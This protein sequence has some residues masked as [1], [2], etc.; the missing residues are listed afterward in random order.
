MPA[1]TVTFKNSTEVLVEWDRK[2]HMG[3]PIDSYEVLVAHQ[4]LRETAELHANG[5]EYNML[6]SLDTVVENQDWSP[7]CFN[8]SLTNLY[9]FS[10]RAVTVDGT[11]KHYRGNWSDVRVTPAYCECKFYFSSSRYFR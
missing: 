3:G 9:N 5:D 4:A 7:D 1:P 6:V 11:G 2:F 8:E 10:V